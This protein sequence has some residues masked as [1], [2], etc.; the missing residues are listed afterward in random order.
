MDDGHADL[1]L[2]SIEEQEQVLDHNQNAA[3][4]DYAPKT[5]LAAPTPFLL[6]VFI[7]PAEI[8]AL[9]EDQEAVEL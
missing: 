2:D 6:G 5:S 3:D 4:H 9:F 8:L 7:A 1:V